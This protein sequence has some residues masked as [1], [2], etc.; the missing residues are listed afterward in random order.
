[1]RWLFKKC[2]L[3]VSCQ[4]ICMLHCVCC[5]FGFSVT[6]KKSNFETFGLQKVLPPLSTMNRLWSAVRQV[7]A[8][9]SSG[10]GSLINVESRRFGRRYRRWH[11]WPNDFLP[12]KWERPTQDP[13]YLRTG[14]AVRDIGYWD[15]KSLVPGAE[16]SKELQK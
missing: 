1:M 7:V 4:L 10:T 14:D 15:K 9:S 16:H 3:T 2:V 8:F 6:T 11:H 5:D 12:F 13:P